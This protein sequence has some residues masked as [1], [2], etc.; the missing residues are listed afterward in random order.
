VRSHGVDGRAQGRGRRPGWCVAAPTSSSL[1]RGA[2]PSPIDT[3]SPEHRVDVPQARL[4]DSRLAPS[5]LHV[6]SSTVEPHKGQG[7][8]HL[9]RSPQ[10]VQAG[11]TREGGSGPAE[12]PIHRTRQICP[13]GLQARPDAR[14]F[15]FTITFRWRARG[16]DA[17]HLLLDRAM[18]P[19]QVRFSTRC[20]S[21]LGSGLGAIAAGIAYR[22]L[23]RGR[24][25]AAEESATASSSSSAS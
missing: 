17:R 19:L 21:S 23:G 24:G 1:D 25:A 15:A 16:H 8:P 14:S 4:A 18:P 13:N 3:S 12:Q 11:A 9:A 2:S 5:L 20:D 6:S 7:I 10:D 22:S